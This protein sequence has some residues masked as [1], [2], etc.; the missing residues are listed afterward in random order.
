MTS[1]TGR[2][3][4]LVIRGNILGTQTWSTGICLDAVV[5]SYTQAEVDA[6]LAAASTL[7][8][9]FW[10]NGTTT[11]W[12]NQ[13]STAT[14]ISGL[15]L[16]VYGEGGEAAG[17]TIQ[18]EYLYPTALVGTGNNYKPTQTALVATMLTGVPGRSFKGRSYMPCTSAAIGA[19]H[20]LTQAQVTALAASWKLLL[21]GLASVAG[22]DFGD[23]IVHGS[24]GSIPITAVRVD[25]ELDIQRRRADKILATFRGLAVLA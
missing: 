7:V 16:Y 9:S 24:R 14:T 6:F 2:F 25:S 22:A 1:P 13:N 8:G 17:A 20:Q 5:L 21:D 12:Q 3:A 10:T 19:T 11:T 4:R 15:A 23:P 18:G